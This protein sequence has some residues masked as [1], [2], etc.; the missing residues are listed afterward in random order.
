MS[1]VQVLCFSE[2]ASVIQDC[3]G[4]IVGKRLGEANPLGI[5]IKLVNEP[6]LADFLSPNA[7]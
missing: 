4:N 6:R 5:A 3:P 1:Q 7:G 2:Q